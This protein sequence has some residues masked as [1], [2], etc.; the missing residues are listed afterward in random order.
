MTHIQPYRVRILIAVLLLGGAGVAYAQ[1]VEIREDTSVSQQI[2]AKSLE[3][4]S[5]PVPKTRPTAPRAVD[6]RNR[7]L[8]ENEEKRQ[9]EMQ[10]K[11]KGMIQRMENKVENKVEH[12]NG[13]IE[14]MFERSQEHMQ[15]QR[16]KVEERRATVEEKINTRL[17][18]KR[19]DIERRWEERKVRLT[20]AR[21]GRIR[22]HIQK[23]VEH[24]KAVIAR[25]ASLAD[26]VEVRITKLA[27]EGTDVSVARGLL[28][29]AR[30]K[31]A[32]A[33]AAL[34]KARSALEAG[35]SAENPGQA[36]DEA[37][38]IFE[39]V[40]SALREAHRALVDAIV[41]VKGRSTGSD[42]SDSSL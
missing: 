35:P 24:V 21:K 26:K 37:K 16:S 33:E 39:D 1:R 27:D 38:V 9:N 42:S 8:R 31:I 13:R 4:E 14:Q 11:N 5:E 2:K 23:M 10:K 36:F 22:T 17:Q 12:M 40:K 3:V 18:E 7:M 20:D 25:L 32:D 34:D 19:A 6:E 41:S 28:T 30:T 29:T 15:E